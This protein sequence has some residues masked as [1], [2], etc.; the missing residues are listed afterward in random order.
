MPCGIIA[1][2]IKVSVIPPGIVSIVPFTDISVTDVPAVVNPL[3]LI[4]NVVASALLKGPAG[5]ILETVIDS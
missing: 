2:G 1:P 3:P 4:V 5:I